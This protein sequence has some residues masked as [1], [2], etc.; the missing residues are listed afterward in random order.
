MNRGRKHVASL[1]AGARLDALR[2]IAPY[3]H[4]AVESASLFDEV[5][6]EA[7]RGVDIGDAL[8]EAVPSTVTT[9]LH[10]ALRGLR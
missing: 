5:D 7:P 9:R 10:G 2:G 8:D 3:R 6:H 1:D 4:E